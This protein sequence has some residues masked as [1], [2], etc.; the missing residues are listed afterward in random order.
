M[1]DLGFGPAG[2]VQLDEVE[3]PA[4][5]GPDWVR[6]RPSL[7]GVCGSDLAAVTG[8]D[9]FMLE[10][11]AA[12]PFTLGHE[13]VAVVQEA[14]AQVSGWGAGE[15]VVVNPILACRQR[16][17]DPACDACER[18]EYG[19][20]RNFDDERLGRGFSTGY[21]PRVGGGWSESFVA[22]ESQLFAAD[23]L[24]DELAVLAD[25]LASALRPVLLHPPAADDVVLVIG[26][27]TIGLLTIVALRAT[28]WTGPIAVAARHP[29]Q[30]ERAR[31]AG[32]EPVLERADRTFD[33][34]TALP[35]AKAYAPDFAPRYV[36]GGPSLIY[37]TVGSE[38]TL[39]DGVALTREG[40][41][42]VLVGGA[43]RV[44]V[45]W[46]RVWYR[47]ITVAGVIAYGSTPWNGSIADS[48]VPAL[49]IIRNG[50]LD[51]LELVT[52]VFGLDEYRAA[53][54]AALS[55]DDS[56]AIKI[57]FRPDS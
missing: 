15:R 47:Q 31:R 33:W 34:A 45:D 37:D 55:K 39:Q 8:H 25:P 4:L 32:A 2:F 20:C 23:P 11:F 26:A 3:A 7:S 56:G 29:A 28:G 9:S 1:P 21:C 17:I 41:R 38:R 5:P 16:G 13:N 51:Q 53:L 27:G 48:Y 43:A 54:R 10:P 19:L 6:L 50:A 46:T 49:E 52:H 42:L 12:F 22:H 14:G 36:E 40:G 35:G 30:R 24:D 57:A 44:S 18:G